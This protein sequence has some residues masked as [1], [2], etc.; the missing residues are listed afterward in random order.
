MPDE[1][2]RLAAVGPG[3]IVGAELL[4]VVLAEHI[5]GQGRAGGHGLRRAGLAG[6]A[7]LYFSGGA[8]GFAGGGRHLLADGVNGFPHLFQ[9]LFSHKNSVLLGIAGA[10]AADQLRAGAG[11]ENVCFADFGKA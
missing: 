10:L 4:H 6:G 7:E 5:D 8:P 3:V 2:A 11:A 9:C 1:M